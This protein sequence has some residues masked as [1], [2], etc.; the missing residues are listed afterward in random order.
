MLWHSFGTGDVAS[1]ST[2]ARGAGD[3]KRAGFGLA[4]RH[5]AVSSEK[6]VALADFKWFGERRAMDKKCTSAGA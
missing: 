3:A 2:L 6:A 5:G 4:G 1:Q